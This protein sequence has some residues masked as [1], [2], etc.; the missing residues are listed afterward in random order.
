MLPIPQYVSKTFSFPVNLAAFLI[1]L[2]RTKVCF[3]FN[4]KNAAGEI[5]NFKSPNLPLIFSLPA[6]CITSSPN[7]SIA[8]G[9]LLIV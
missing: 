9:S 7:I 6:T 3:E 4:W 1:S 2:Y 8:L 5:S